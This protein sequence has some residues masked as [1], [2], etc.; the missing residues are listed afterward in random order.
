MKN[1]LNSVELMK[2]ISEN[3]QIEEVVIGGRNV[4]VFI[5]NES[6]FLQFSKSEYYQFLVD[7]GFVRNLGEN[8]DSQFAACQDHDYRN[9]SF[10]SIFHFILMKVEDA[11]RSE[12]LKKCSLPNLS[13]SFQKFKDAITNNLNEEINKL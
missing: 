9:N 5:K 6:D 1:H 13:L 10:D 4:E 7:D 8:E 3:T 2:S 12:K 11:E